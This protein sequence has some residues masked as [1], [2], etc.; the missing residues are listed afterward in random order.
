MLR[1]AHWMLRRRPQLPQ[2]RYVPGRRAGEVTRFSERAFMG[3]S[4]L[5]T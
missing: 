4:L 5:G 2:Q 1:V 3:Y